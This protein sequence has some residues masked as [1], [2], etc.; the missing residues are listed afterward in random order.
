MVPLGCESRSP[1]GNVKYQK[2]GS[3]GS[4]FYVLEA[5]HAET[6]TTGEA[7]RLPA[8]PYRVANQYF[9]GVARFFP[10]PF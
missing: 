5:V 4:L 6:I 1:N 8:G 3:F 2:P 7:P 9:T 10:A